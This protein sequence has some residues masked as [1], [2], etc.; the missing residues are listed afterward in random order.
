MKLAK[1]SSLSSLG[2]KK[3]VVAKRKKPVKEE[4]L[5]SE[6]SDEEVAKLDGEGSLDGNEEEED[7]GTVTVEKG[8]MKK[9]KLDLEK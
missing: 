7:D 6:S 4:E 2:K 1:K 9:H 8:G 5:P 3:Q